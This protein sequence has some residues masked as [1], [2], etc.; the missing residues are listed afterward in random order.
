MMSC[1]CRTTSLRIF[2]QSLTELR[3]SSSTV[4]KTRR[5]QPRHPKAVDFRSQFT[6]SRPFSATTALSFQQQTS[7]SANSDA[8]TESGASEAAEQKTSDN[9]TIDQAHLKALK[10]SPSDLDKAKRDGAILDYSPESIDA[11]VANLD[12][13]ANKN[14]TPRDEPVEPAFPDLKP[15]PTPLATSSKLKRLKI[16]KEEPKKGE[17]DSERP[18]KKEHWQIQKS[19]LKEK[20]PEGWSPRKRLSPDALDG[21]RALHSQFPEDYTTEVLAE[22]FQVSPEAIRRILKSKWQPNPEE[23]I[24]RQERWFN[25]GKN[26]WTQMAALGKKPPRRWRKEGIVRDPY[27]NRPRGPRTQPPKQ[28]RPRSLDDTPDL[29]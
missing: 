6:F 29:R 19:A 18:T 15:S 24:R 25:R 20:F 12:K 4:A 11:L 28:R 5:I 3:L 14:L 22:K 8:A 27:W 10:A 21:I 17:E 26:I 13:S 7:K 16:F 23:E 9:G 1:S 2:V